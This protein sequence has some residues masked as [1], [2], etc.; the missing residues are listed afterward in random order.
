M[1]LIY[2][3]TTANGFELSSV[4]ADIYAAIIAKVNS[5]WT[6]IN[7]DVDIESGLVD[8]INAITSPLGITLSIANINLLMDLYINK[9]TQLQL[10]ST[11]M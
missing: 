5:S 2:N 10:H 3:N 8:A 9:L 4:D 6:D 7:Y 11:K 1:I